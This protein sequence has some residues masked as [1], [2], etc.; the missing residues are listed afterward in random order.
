M[1]DVMKLV[2]GWTIVGAFLFTTV[3]T[4]LS[5]VGVIRFA[6]ASQQRRLFALLILQIVVG[7]GAQVLDVADYDPEPLRK[8]LE[9]RRNRGDADTD[10]RTD[11]FPGVRLPGETDSIRVPD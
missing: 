3:I 10:P 5:M 11:R 6:D 4:C 9:L 7:V 1:D 8:V 2:V